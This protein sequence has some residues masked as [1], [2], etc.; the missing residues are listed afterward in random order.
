MKYSNSL[1]RNSKLNNM[2]PLI[3]IQPK[4]INTTASD[5]WILPILK[6]KSKIIKG[7]S[8]KLLNSLNSNN[9]L[10]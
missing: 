10:N 1:E 9:I 5:A 2:I 8:P 3:S 6:S 4:N 7:P